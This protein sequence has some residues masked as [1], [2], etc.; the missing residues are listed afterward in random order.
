LI[1][2][3]Y[4]DAPPEGTIVLTYSFEELLAE[5]TRAL[6]ERSRPRDLYDV[7][8]LLENAPSD[9]N[10]IEVRRLFAERCAGKGVPVPS[11]AELIGIVGNDADRIASTPAGTARRNYSAVETITS[12]AIHDVFDRARCRSRLRF[13]P[14]SAYTS[15]TTIL[16][17]SLS[18]LAL[19]LRKRRGK[20]QRPE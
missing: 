16:S 9:L 2:H 15:S 12:S 19:P 10:L 4:P 11:S 17:G 5:K 8:H 18:L 20:A 7:V 3:P 1:L 6:L 14:S 13:A